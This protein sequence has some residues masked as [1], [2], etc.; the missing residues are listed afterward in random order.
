MKEQGK[1]IVIYSLNPPHGD[2]RD[3]Q[4]G[5]IVSIYDDGYQNLQIARITGSKW[6]RKL[7]SKEISYH[8][9]IITK[10]QQINPREIIR[11]L[12]LKPEESQVPSLEEQEKE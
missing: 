8:G 4:E 10:S 11:A 12:R 9:S 1:Y 6:T 3:I 5:D 7:F 2:V